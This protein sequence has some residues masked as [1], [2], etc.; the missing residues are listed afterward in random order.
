[1]VRRLSEHEKDLTGSHAVRK[2]APKLH[3]NRPD[4]PR[5]RDL[6]GD[7]RAAREAAA[8]WRR[9]VP[10]LDKAG[11]LTR[12]DDVVVT[13]AAVCWARIR[14]CERELGRTGLLITGQKGNLVRNPVSLTLSSYRQSLQSYVKAL[15]LSPAA[16]QG[17]DLPG[18]REGLSLVDKLAIQAACDRRGITVSDDDFTWGTWDLVVPD[19]IAR[20]YR[21]R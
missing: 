6:L 7:E 2:N 16:R 8:W 4:P 17:M 12:V 14:Q 11:V 3:P 1:M 15:G 10:E 18:P 20:E 5:W 19:D 9:V 13:E 21:R